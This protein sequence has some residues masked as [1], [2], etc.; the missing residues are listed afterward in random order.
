MSKKTKEAAIARVAAET[1]K[2]KRQAIIKSLLAA[3]LFIGVGYAAGN[4][5]TTPLEPSSA[6]TWDIQKVY[7][8]DIAFGDPK[9][10]VR[11]TEYGSLTCIHCSQFHRESLPSLI[12][13]Y[14]DTGKAY[15]VFRHFPY[16][17]SGL[18]G[19]QAVSC[20]PAEK[21]AGAVSIMMERQADWVNYD[22]AGLAALDLLGLSPEERAKAGE[23]V[24]KDTHSQAVGEV[25]MEARR[26][27]ISSTPTFVVGKEVYPGFI[28]PSAFGRIIARAAEA[29]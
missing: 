9:A 13:D 19:A 18:A 20:L 10:P 15:L 4:Y 25:A 22:K 1:K 26:N 23:C 14:V 2:R 3:T 29:R 12:E 7:P 28:G 21:R 17:A 27:G 6:A 11:I 5:I 16:D 24:E 8:T